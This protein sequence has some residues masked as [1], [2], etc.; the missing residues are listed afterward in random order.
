ML[1][2][3]GLDDVAHAVYKN[4][5]AGGG[6][7]IEEIAAQ[8]KLP[9][10]AVR[11]SIDRLLGLSLLRRHAG[12]LQPGSPTTALESLLQRQSADLARRQQE[13][14]ETRAAVSRLTAE[15][16]QTWGSRQVSE[17][18]RL[19]GVAAIQGR[20]E[21]R[22]K[23]ARIECLSLLPQ[24]TPLID[25]LDARAELDR[26]LVHNG[27]S[28]W[29]VLLN[30]A[31]NDR[32]AA[33]YAER[34]AD[35]GGEARAIPSLP[36]WLVVFDRNSALIPAG[37]ESDHPSA[38]EV[39]CPGVLTAL[40]ALFE[41][42]WSSATELSSV[43]AVANNGPTAMERELLRLLGQGLTDEAV[44]KKLGI[45]LRTA[46]RMVADLM[47]RL[48][49]RSRFEAGANAV[50]KGWLDPC[51]S[52]SERPPRALR[53]GKCCSETHSHRIAH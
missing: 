41:R 8:L 34:L 26:Q 6:E 4:V 40:V 38:F 10:S 20:Q 39:T 29:T 12:A 5:L 23:Q 17:W 48:D 49:A 42:I 7:D 18:E 13:L 15:Y 27:A 43:R 2:T 52:T 45:G 46:R 14:A 44:S 22:T 24:D 28:V 19:D 11:Q 31:C 30:S 37:L 16:D 35:L 1:Q 50:N 3:L 51:Q 36:T 33:A 53:H 25:D 9:E 21:L 47:C 32:V